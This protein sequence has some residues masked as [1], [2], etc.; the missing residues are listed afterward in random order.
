VEESLASRANGRQHQWTESTAVGGKR[1]VEELK[2]R[3]GIKARSRL[4][5]KGDGAYELREPQSFYGL[6]SDPQND[7]LRPENAHFWG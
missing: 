4:P 1:F 5:E 3:I 6:S 7:A 2:T